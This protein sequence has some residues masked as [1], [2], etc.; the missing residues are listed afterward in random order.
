MTF[1][2]RVML[3]ML[4]LCSIGIVSMKP[5][6]KPILLIL[7]FLFVMAGVVGSLMIILI[8][9]TSGYTHT[10]GETILI[11]W[12][13][14]FFISK[15]LI[16]YVSAMF[17]KRICSLSTAILFI[18]AITPSELA[19]GFNKLGMPYKICTVISLAFRTIP[20][21]ARDYIDIKNSLMMRGVELDSRKAS[22]GKRLKQTVFILSPLIMTSFGRIGTIANAMD[23]RG[24]SKHKQRTW[25]SERDPTAADWVARAIILLVAAFCVYYIVYI[26]IMNPPPFSYWTPWGYWNG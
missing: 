3:P 8:R 7:S 24:F 21:I 11:Q 25:Y 23:L 12:T 20:D 13:N 22:L 6:W 15:E 16:W 14:H 18:L 4:I 19:A 2:V 10:G 5:N 17:F 26:R 1:D 9:P